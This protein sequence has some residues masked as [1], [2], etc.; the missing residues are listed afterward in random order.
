MRKIMKKELSTN[1]IYVGKKSDSVRGK[2]YVS[3]RSI[4]LIIDQEIEYENPVKEG[5][6]V[7]TYK[8]KFKGNDDL[9][10]HGQ[11]GFEDFCN[12]YHKI[13][14]QYSDE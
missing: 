1:K 11:W 12:Y 9:F 7:P 13:D 2:V 4:A 5:Y 14:R 3:I 10:E 8:H 6:L